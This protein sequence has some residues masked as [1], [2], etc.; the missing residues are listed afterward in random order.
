MEETYQNIK[1]IDIE[2]TIGERNSGL[3][4]KL[5]AF[6]IKIMTRIIHQDEINYILNKYSNDI[7]ADFLEKVI[8]EFNIKCKDSDIHYMI[9]K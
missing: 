9:Y 4:K 7:G 5:P 8:K 1:Y 3:L 2:K 6:V